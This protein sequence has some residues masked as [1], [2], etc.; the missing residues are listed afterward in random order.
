MLFVT[1]AKRTSKRDVA[2]ALER[3][4]RV[5]APVIGLVLNQASKE[6]GSG[7]YGYGYGYNYTSGASAVPPTPR[8]DIDEQ[9]SS[10][11][12]TA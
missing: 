6:S 2:E 11:V 4:A 1:E 9:P 10:T 12:G 8:V 3:L 5:Q 7:A